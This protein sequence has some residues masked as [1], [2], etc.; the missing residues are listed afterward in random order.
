[1]CDKGN[2]KSENLELVAAIDFCRLFFVVVLVFFKSKE[3]Q[4]QTFPID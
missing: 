2:V 4:N 3:T 1:M